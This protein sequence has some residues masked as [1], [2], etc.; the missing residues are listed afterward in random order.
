MVLVIEQKDGLKYKSQTYGIHLRVARVQKMKTIDFWTGP[1]RTTISHMH[2]EALDLIEWN[3]LTIR[4]HKQLK[5]SPCITSHLLL[6]YFS[7]MRESFINKSCHDQIR[8]DREIYIDVNMTNNPK[9]N[10]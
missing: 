3:L 5:L 7:N 8:I 2:F 6:W 1:Y 4:F 10:L 9:R